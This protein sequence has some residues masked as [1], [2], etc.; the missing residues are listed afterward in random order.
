M[1]AFTVLF[2]A[3]PLSPHRVDPYFADQATLVREL[4]GATA[5]VDH[6]AV[7]AGNSV[8]AVRR[9]PVDAGPVWYRGWMIPA[10]RYA[11]LAT[12]LAGRGTP[13]RVPPDDYRAAHELPGWYATF[14]AVT[15]E[16]VWMPRQPL[17]P[18]SPGEIADLV[19]SLGSGPAIV[20]DY[21]KSRKHEWAEACYLPDLADLDHATRVITRLIE[22]QDD[23]LQGGIVVRRFEDYG[24]AAGRTA[25][26][27]AWWVDAEPVLVSAHP[28]TP[29]LAP[30]PDL[31][32][33]APLVAALGGRFVTTDLAL[34]ADG[35]WRVVEVGDGQVSDLP[36]T[37]DAALLFSAL[38]R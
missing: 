32:A 19:S 36:P 18:P 28:D 7:L 24:R 13:L 16:S 21:V 11:E 9:V 37:A 5:L 10:D 1:A 23:T 31:R 27:R 8:T 14:A 6:D 22:L 25:E 33:V 3:D 4:G 12:V 38:A 30:H 29:D 15:P 2:C 17:D 35:E 20:K 26:A 34:R